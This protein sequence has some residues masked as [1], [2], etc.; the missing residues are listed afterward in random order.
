MPSVILDADTDLD[1]LTVGEE[2][3]GTGPFML[4]E[5]LPEERVTMVR[6]PDYWDGLPYLDELV[7]V[8]IA[9]TFSP[10]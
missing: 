7:F 1:K 9:G 6:N 10:A 2:A 4:E 5:L 8:G 3:Y